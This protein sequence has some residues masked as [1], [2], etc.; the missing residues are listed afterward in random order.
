MFKH[1]YIKVIYF[2]MAIMPVLTVEF[3]PIL[4]SYFY[5]ILTELIWFNV[6]SRSQTMELL[7]NGS[8]DCDIV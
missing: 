2:Y 1:I 4:H 3:V 8:N 7:L 6:Q 5:C